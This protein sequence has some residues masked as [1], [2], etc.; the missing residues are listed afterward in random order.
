MSDLS[1]ESSIVEMWNIALGLI[2]E[3]RRKATKRGINGWSKWNQRFGSDP[4]EESNSGALA[5]S[6]SVAQDA[7]NALEREGDCSKATL[8]LKSLASTFPERPS[9]GLA[10]PTCGEDDRTWVA[11]VGSRT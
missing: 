3:K 8:R 11:L 6:S 1:A 7:P 10:T 2:R 4:H 5:D 9:R